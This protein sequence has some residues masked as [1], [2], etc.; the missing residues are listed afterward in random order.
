MRKQQEKSDKDKVMAKTKKETQG[1]TSVAQDDSWM[2]ECAGQGLDKITQD[3]TGVAYLSMIQ[4]GSQYDQP[5]SP[6]GQWRNSATGQVYGPNIKVM[7]VD[8]TTIWSE[9]DKDPPFM[10][11]GKY[12]PGSLKPKIVKPPAGKRGYPKMY[13]PASGNEI[14][15][16]PAY[17]LR[18]VDDEATGVAFFIPSVSSLK[19]VK[20]WAGKLKTQR[21]S[22][23][24][25]APLQ[26]FIWEL[27]I[28]LIKNPQKASEKIA[29]LATSIRGAPVD[30]EFYF[31]NVKPFLGSANN[32]LLIGASEE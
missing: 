31:K 27:G 12:P 28:E 8:I 1:K 13:N 17:A 26:G 3:M 7:V 20:T 18:L 32:V 10:S 6:A 15:E 29:V 23:G 4:P 24:K 11:V 9:R 22:S 21:T 5:E 25:S 19:G 30:P 2:D 14:L 16:L